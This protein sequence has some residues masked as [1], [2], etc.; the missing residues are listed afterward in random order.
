MKIW[1]D[2]SIELVN[3]TGVGAYILTLIK[4]VG[5]LGYKI[6]QKEFKINKKIKF[7]YFFLLFWQ[8]T[9]LHLQILLQKPDVVIF[10]NFVMPYIKRKKTKYITVI[11]DLCILRPS[12]SNRYTNLV[13]SMSTL[14]T[15]KNAD[16]IVTVSNTIRKELIE[17]YH[18]LPDKIFVVNNTIAEHFIE[19]QKKP[20]IIQQYGL[21]KNQY[22]LSVAT[23]NIRKNIPKLTKAFESISDRYPDLKLVLVGGMGS[24]K[25]EKLSK[26]KNI[27]FT[28]YLKDEDLPTLYKN[29]LLYMYPSLYE[30]FGIPL[31]EAQYCNCPV[32]CSD[33]PI[34]REV[35]NDSAEFCEPN[36]KDI[37]EKMEYLINNPEKLKEIREKGLEN[38]KHF[39]IE[40]IA[41]QLKEVLNV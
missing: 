19:A 20:E 15:I 23:L 28:G 3:K 34:F 2:T 31:I 13:Y 30:G 10:P 9:I 24:E 38:V 8:N 29:A 5:Q 37:A 16:R 39:Y 41:E 7:K 1:I 14:N 40:R 18:L 12:E 25:R 33:I 22:I 32:L 6:T 4:A 35:A 26:H 21:R 36:S 17:K 27:I 11:H